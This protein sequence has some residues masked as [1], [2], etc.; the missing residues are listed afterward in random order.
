MKH[1]ASI[2][3]VFCFVVSSAWAQDDDAPGLTLM[4]RGALMFME[5]ILKEMEP[6]IEELSELTDQ[7]GPALKE[8]AQEMGPKLKEMLNEVEDWSVYDA[9]EILPNGDIIIRRKPEAPELKRY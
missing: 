1:L 9:P 7:M 4:E 8:F 6:A 5:G 3:V 2:S